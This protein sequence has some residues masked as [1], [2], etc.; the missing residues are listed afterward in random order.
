MNLIDTY[1][2]RL[3]WREDGTVVFTLRIPLK[4]AAG[5]IAS[6]TVQRPTLGDLLA[7]EKATGDDLTKVAMTIVRLTGVKMAE[8]DEADAGDPMI[9]AEVIVKMMEHGEDGNILDRHDD[10]LTITEYDTSL[11]LLTPLATPHGEVD[12]IVVRRPSW[13]ET[14]TNQGKTLAATMR[15]LAVLTGLGPNALGKVDA[16]DGLILSALVG[17]FLGNSRQPPPGKP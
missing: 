15:L 5:E 6:I 2:D 11:R 12:E 17:D 9:L 4:T 7:N 13:K 1:A 3:D 16:V 14:K 10:R 8:L